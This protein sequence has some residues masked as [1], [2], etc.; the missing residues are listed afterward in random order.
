MTKREQAALNKSYHAYKRDW[1]LWKNK[2]W[3]MKTAAPM[4]FDKYKEMYADAK[5]AGLPNIGSHLASASRTIDYQEAKD[6]KAMVDKLDKGFDSSF[7][8]DIEKK[9]SSLSK[10]KKNIGGYTTT[11]D[12]VLYTGKQAVYLDIRFLYG[13]T[14][15]NEYYGY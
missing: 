10:I 5:E 14:K 15:A 7:D 2:G 8:A 13:V 11:I 12:G 3:S 6:L 1:Y 4:D 9:F